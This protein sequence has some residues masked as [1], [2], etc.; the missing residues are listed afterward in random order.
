MTN[1]LQHTGWSFEDFA[2]DHHKHVHCRE[3]HGCILDL[4]LAVQLSMPVWCVG[5]RDT[6]K[7]L[8]KKGRSTPWRKMGGWETKNGS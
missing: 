2:T 8:T 7:A 5:C 3:C 4:H 6:I 1:V